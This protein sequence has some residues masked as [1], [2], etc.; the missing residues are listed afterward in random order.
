MAGPSWRSSTW[1]SRATS[2]A[3]AVSGNWGGGDVVAV[4]L[5]ALDDA[6]P[7]RAAGPSA[8]DKHDV[9]SSIHLG[10]P[11]MVGSYCHRAKRSPNAV[12]VTPLHFA[13]ACWA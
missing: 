9:R 5:Q 8:V 1:R 2:S 10:G 13:D 4:G 7:G 12:C 11:F 6:A 3:S